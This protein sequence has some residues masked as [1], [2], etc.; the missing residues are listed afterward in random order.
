MTS[1]FL[2]L[3]VCISL[4]FCASAS[5]QLISM[6]S[7]ANDSLADFNTRMPTRQAA[8]ATSVREAET[9]GWNLYRYD[10]LAD[11][12]GYILAGQTASAQRAAIRGSIVVPGDTQWTVRFYTKTAAGEYAPVYDVLVDDMGRFSVVP[13]SAARAFSGSELAL[14]RA[15]E[16][17]QSS[18]PDPCDSVYRTV[19]IPA[20]AGNAILV[21]RLRDCLDANRLP[22]GQHVRYDVST[23]GFSIVAERD[24]SRRC[25]LLA[26]QVNPATGQENIDLSNTIDPQPTELHI[27]LSLHYG[28]NIYLATLKSNLYWH[29]NRGIVR[30]D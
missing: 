24:F 12:A 14:I 20:P 4:L 22:E 23:D 3:T 11:L 21:Y 18:K 26:T 2:P 1:R 7:A 25:N 13:G 30:A 19:A 27:Y 8:L 15:T 6:T 17:I 16:L 9:L 5:A 28:V 29:I 10:T